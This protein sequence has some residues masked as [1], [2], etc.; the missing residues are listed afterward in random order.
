MTT[1][2]LVTLITV[3][4]PKDSS[5]MIQM[6]NTETASLKQDGIGV[7]AMTRMY[8]TVWP[9]PQASDDP[10]ITVDSS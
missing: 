10:D 5:G 3:R 6:S 7:S 9:G 8:E 4:L 1:E 2:R